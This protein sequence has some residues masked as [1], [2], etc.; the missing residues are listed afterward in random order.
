[1]LTITLEKIN[2]PLFLS[3]TWK[4]KDYNIPLIIK[5]EN[6]NVELFILPPR[7]GMESIVSIITYGTI[8]ISI[9][10]P[11]EKLIAGLEHKSLED[12]EASAISIFNIYKKIMKDLADY[13]RFGLSLQNIFEI[14]ERFYDLFSNNKSLSTHSVCWK[15]DN[16]E[17]K[18]F[19]YDVSRGEIHPAF[20][21]DNLVSPELWNKLQTF[22]ETNNP[23]THEISELLELRQK[24]FW[25]ENKIPSIESCAIVEYV[26]R[27][28]IRKVLLEQGISKNKIDDSKK[29]IGM[30]ILLNLLV[31]MSMTKDDYLKIQNDIT[32]IDTLR[33][34]RNDVIHNGLSNGKIESKRVYEGIDSAI[35]LLVFLD[36]KFK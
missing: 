31:P 12:E 22:I 1:M 11:E 4:D 18:E 30:S 15:I 13:A 10:N 35:K 21:E 7:E 24:A 16:E 2:L 3:T 19:R 8:I 26:L 5:N 17:Y 34:V 33:K 9:A 29:E 36:E 28:K 23:P 6:Y 25:E 32:N 27:D 14:K 20:K